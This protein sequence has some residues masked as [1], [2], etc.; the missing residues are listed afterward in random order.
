MDYK[1]TNTYILMKVTAKPKITISGEISNPG[2]V[3]AIV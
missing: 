3:S 2:G 1:I